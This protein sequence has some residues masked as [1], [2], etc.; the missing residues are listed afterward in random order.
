MGKKKLNKIQMGKV[1][2]DKQLNELNASS[3]FKQKRLFQIEDELPADPMDWP[4]RW[5]YTYEEQAAILECDWEM[6][7]SVAEKLAEKYVRNEH[8][9]AREEEIN[10]DE[11]VD[12]ESFL[13]P[14]LRK[15]KK[16]K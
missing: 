3:S 8:K 4:A 16:K 13:P 7:R 1:F 2:T 9:H 5:L 12:W 14:D 11:I 10:W 15:R 6:E